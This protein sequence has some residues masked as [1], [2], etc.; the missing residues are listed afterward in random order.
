MPPA[1]GSIESA[2]LAATPVDSPTVRPLAPQGNK[3][4]KALPAAGRTGPV[5]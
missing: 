1:I 2:A 5:D 4:M 3:T